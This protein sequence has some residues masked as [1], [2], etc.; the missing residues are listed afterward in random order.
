MSDKSAKRLTYFG[1][2][3]V[4]F[5]VL[6]MI[7]LALFN[8]PISVWYGILMFEGFGTGCMISPWISVL[9]DHFAEKHNRTD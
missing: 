1:M 3:M 9:L 4:L 6:V 8:I 5:T 2:I 7:P